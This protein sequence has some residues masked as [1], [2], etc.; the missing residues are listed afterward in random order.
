MSEKHYAFFQNRDCEFFPCHSGVAE[1]EFNCLFCYCPLYA[2][3]E[4]C[5]GGYVYL[6]N[7]VKSCEHCNFPH[8][9]ENYR[10]VLSRF[11]EL[12]ALAGKR[13][14]KDV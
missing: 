12:A 13:E 1:E 3:G 4:G 11:D 8:K 2:L 14:D 5:G 10:A 7:G 6:D 9:R